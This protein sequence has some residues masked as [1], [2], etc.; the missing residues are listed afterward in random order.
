MG[1]EEPIGK[2]EWQHRCH[3]ASQGFTFEGTDFRPCGTTYHLQ[4]IV[5]GLPF[6]T[7]LAKDGGLSFPAVAV[8]P[9]FV[10]EAC[11]VRAML[12]RELTRGAR[13]RTLL[14]LERM[15]LVDQA[16]SW[17]KS[18]LGNYQSG[19]LRIRRFEENFGVVA[20]R[21]TP[22]LH[23]PASPAIALMWAQQQY[24]LEM[25]RNPRAGESEF[26]TFDTSRMLRSAA[27][28]FYTW[29]LQIA[30]P[31][32]A[33]R[34]AQRRGHLTERCL[35]T[36]ELGYAMM[37]TGMA[38]RMGTESRPSVALQCSH[39]IAMD[40]LWHQA[41]D[42]TIDLRAHREISAAAVTNLIAWLG[43]LRAMETFGLSWD[44]V[45]VTVPIDGALLG[46]PLGMG[47]IQLRLLSQ[48]KSQRT[49]VADCVI[50]HTTKFSK[51]SLGLWIERMR[52]LWPDHA[53]G[54]VPLIWGGSGNRWT[55][56]DYRR[57]HLYPML[58]TLRDSGDPQLRPYDD[59]PGNSIE[60]KFYSM[61]SY[62]RGGRSYVSKRRGNKLKATP[63]EIYEHGRWRKKRAG[64]DMPTRYQEFTLEDRLYLTYLC[65]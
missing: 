17:A 54:G 46:L 49:Q 50:A 24:C 21:G 19:L 57:N 63:T 55:S 12:G 30:Y 22:L 15:R 26:V 56:R 42:D 27:S 36:D 14:M 8:S 52:A 28:Y 1:C 32:R 2:L 34:D 23:P 6:R 43:W 29:D 44:D 39:I 48:T 11:T 16:H 4:C 37:A 18:T 40:L 38:R 60:E 5:V 25:T 20:L 7:R 3:F 64:E 33:M 10:C 35:P 31:G 47:A 45:T 58:R 65:M 41:W 59:R 13:D 61:C 51:L 62:R 53:D 9:P